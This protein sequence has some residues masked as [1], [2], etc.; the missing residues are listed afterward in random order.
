M[1]KNSIIFGL[2]KSYELAKEVSKL[3]DIP[4]GKSHSNKFLD[5]EILFTTD[6]TIRG[7]NVYLIQSTCKPV[8]DSLME[9]LIAIDAMRRASAKS[10]NVVIPYFG[11]SRQDRKCKGREPITSRLVADMLQVAGATRVLTI[12]IHSQ[13]QQGFFSIPFDSITAMWMLTDVFLKE[14]KIN[15]EDIVVVSPDFGS[16]KRSRAISEKIGI[17]LAIVD[18]K[19]PKPNAVIISNIFGDIEGKYCLM[20]DDI[21]DSGGT[22]ISCAKLLKEKGAKGVI[23]LATHALFNGDANKNFQSAYE[24]G[25]IT[26]MYVTDTTNNIDIPKFIKVLSIAEIVAAAINVY[27][28]NAGESIST[29]YKK[30]KFFQVFE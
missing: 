21:I 23:I 19:R 27:S 26:D 4:L 7:L 13:Q 16:I 30:Y 22:M 11:Y 2:S 18:K 17:N 12:D 5:G 20:I 9:L 25:F 15:M 1:N 10:I 14:N 8:N 29:V 28:G 3:T 6:I 24:E